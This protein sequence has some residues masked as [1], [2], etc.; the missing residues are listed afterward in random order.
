MP[1][2]AGKTV[3]RGEEVTGKFPPRLPSYT[4]AF[5]EF[6]RQMQKE[7]QLGRE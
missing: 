5:W 6:F 7:Q 2:T 1:S 4:G 3:D